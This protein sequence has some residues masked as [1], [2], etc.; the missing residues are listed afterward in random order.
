MQKNSLEFC[1]VGCGY[2]D[3]LE[4]SRGLVEYLVT[5]ETGVADL[6]LIEEPDNPFDPNAIM[7][8]FKGSRVGYVKR[9]D[10]LNVAENFNRIANSIKTIRYMTFN[11]DFDDK[12]TKESDLIYFIVR[13]A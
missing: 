4:G 7:V 12:P 6:T 8:M 9:A 11:N 3:A 13:C 5:S 2:E 1:V 10:I